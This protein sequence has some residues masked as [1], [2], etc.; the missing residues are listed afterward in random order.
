MEAQGRG[1]LA[2]STPESS[3]TAT[4]VQPEESISQSEKLK[5]CPAGKIRFYF[6]S[7]TKITS[8]DIVLDIVNGFK[9]E[10]TRQ[11]N[12]PTFLKNKAFSPA[13]SVQINSEV[14]RLLQIGAIRLL[15]RSEA[16]FVSP[17]FVVPKP[18]GKSRLI[19][20]LK[21]LNMFIE[22]PHFKLE[23]FRSVCNILNEGDY[24]C[25]VD[26]KDA[27]LSVPVSDET[28]RYLCFEFEGKIYAYTVLCFGL[29]LSP[30][31][32]TK[33]CRP[34]ATLT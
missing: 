4:L 11:P 20:N 18:D 30:Y 6:D 34:N 7:W 17:I 15:D 1:Q 16:S 10:F 26:L 24:M 22:A 27:Y 21:R 2:K 28:M 9:L 13:E 5:V 31:L 3:T 29:S 23:D 8:N 14:S 12:V 25:K 33:L 19:L 32:F